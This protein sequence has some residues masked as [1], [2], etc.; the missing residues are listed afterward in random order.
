[1][2]T[3]GCRLSDAKTTVAAVERVVQGGWKALDR[4]RSSGLDL[5]SEID[6]AKAG[7]P[8]HPIT[9]SLGESLMDAALAAVSFGYFPPIRCAWLP[10]V[11]LSGYCCCIPVI[12]ELSTLGLPQACM[13]PH[14]VHWLAHN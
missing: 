7:I 2:Y 5:E 8:P 14:R 13:L 4:Y 3:A 9:K 6:L 12:C 11:L 10:H 1:M